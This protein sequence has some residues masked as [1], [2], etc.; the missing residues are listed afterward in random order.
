[1]AKIRLSNMILQV[2]L[3]LVILLAGVGAGA[4]IINSRPVTESTGQGQALRTVSAVRVFPAVLPVIIESQGTV[5]AQQRISLVPQVAGKV[6]WVSE[7]YLNGGFFQAGETVVRIDDSDYRLA[8]TSAQASVADATQQLESIRAQAEQAEADWALLHR[9]GADSALK[10]TALALRKPQLAGAEARLLSS[11][12]ELEKA[13]LM[14][15][16]TELVAPFSSMLVNKQVDFGQYVNTGTVL[17]YLVSSDVLEV[18]L[19]LPERELERLDLALLEAGIPITLNRL[20][21]GAADMWHGSLIRSEGLIDERTRNLTLVARIQ[22]EQI[23]SVSNTPLTIGQ[24]VKAVIP[25]RAMPG[26][27]TL[28]RTALHNGH[29]VFVVDAENSLREREVT[30]LEV[31]DD[32]ILVQGGLVAGEVVSI[33]LMTSSVEGL[34]VKVVLNEELL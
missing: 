33:S 25:G 2:G 26:V 6:V 11:Q 28:P 31:Y 27:V 14:L 3:P 24:F 29:N 19:A 12:A 5:E 1:M 20:N 30:V 18:R 4:V 13:R 23:M 8:V 22:G 7:K 15:Q 34:H 10:P 9:S 16:R 21:E 32:R 17:A